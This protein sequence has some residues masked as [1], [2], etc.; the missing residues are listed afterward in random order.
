MN[1]FSFDTIKDN[2]KETANNLS[3]TFDELKGLFEKF[4]E[5][6]IFENLKEKI[7]SLFNKDAS[8]S[9][10]VLSKVEGNEYTL[11]SY[12]NN[13]IK[14]LKV[15]NVLLPNDINN[16]TVL[17]YEDGS[18]T[19][20]K[21]AT[22][23]NNKEWELE[24]RPL[25]EKEGKIYMIE[26]MGDDYLEVR[27]VET[28]EFFDFYSIMYNLRMKVQEGDFVQIKDGVAVKYNG[29]I[30]TKSDEAFKEI[31]NTQ[32]KVYLDNRNDLKNLEE[33]SIHVITD[34]DDR[35]LSLINVK[36]GESFHIHTY[37]FEH[38]IES[39]KESGAFDDIHQIKKEDFEKMDKGT[40]VIV[41]NG[42]YIPYEGTFETKNEKA[43]GKLKNLYEE[44][45]NEK[46]NN[47]GMKEKELYRNSNLEMEGAVY[48]I[49]SLKKF[50]DD[51]Y[52]LYNVTNGESCFCRNFKSSEIIE[53]LSEGDKLIFENGE[54]KK[55]YDDLEI[56]NEEI[57]KEIEEIYKRIEK[58]KE[59]M[60]K[61]LQEG[62]IHIVDDL[63]KDCIYLT[64]LQEGYSFKLELTQYPN[65]KVGDF[66][67]GSG[68]DYF[69]YEGEVP[70]GNKEILEKV[71]RIYNY[72]VEIDCY[73]NDK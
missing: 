2:L 36:D 65:F 18:F 33:G 23:E 59:I 27:D 19:I 51:G 34:K 31:L 21:K 48:I 60:D 14:V 69:L 32:N 5:K 72:F 73:K 1:I 61:S 30:E 13:G 56:T 11:L 66:I 53:N 6:N 25:R 8:I 12:E 17:S 22:R 67:K 50:S 20:N 44:I 40:C 68:K 63:Y 43:L 71:G 62:A 49:E 3:E 38:E 41:E 26:E 28:G 70:I 29:K 45:E 4:D 47:N 58:K 55:Y 7:E 16:R 57:R 64:N 46:L 10:D 42:K 52:V 15:P 9:F 35:C 39:I 24:R 54:Y 37:D